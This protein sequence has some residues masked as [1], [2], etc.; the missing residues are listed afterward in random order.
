VSKVVQ[1]MS[2]LDWNISMEKS[3]TQATLR[4]SEAQVCE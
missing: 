4:I 2:L 1:Q 3:D